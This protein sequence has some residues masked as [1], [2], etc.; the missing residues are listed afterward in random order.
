MKLVIID[1][2]L[3]NLLSVHNALKSLNIES[4]V[5][6]DGTHLEDADGVIL[7][8]V[9]AFEDGMK[10]I[11]SKGLI[12]PI[13]EYVK[14]GRPFLGICLGMQMLM[15]KSYEFGEFEGLNLIEG[16][17][18]RFLVETL[19]DGVAL[20]I[21]HIGWNGLYKADLPWEHTILQGI[22][23]KEEMY[24]IH[25]FCVFPRFRQNILAETVYGTQTYCSVVSKENIYGVQF[26]PEKSSHE[27]LRI[28]ANFV[29]LAKGGRKASSINEKQKIERNL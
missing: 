23:N 27:G 4:I 24:F 29:Q 26:H 6:S 3:S 1:Y 28:L 2:G 12:K 17:V 19:E 13:F 22:S 15:T 7:P 5:T 11:S 9:G 14:T 8:G 21:P 10:G 20:K 18:K 25:S 16:E